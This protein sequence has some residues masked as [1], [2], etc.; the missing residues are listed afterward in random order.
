MITVDFFEN[1][2]ILLAPETQEELNNFPIPQI[3]IQNYI[4]FNFNFVQ[5]QTQINVKIIVV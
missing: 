1:I 2:I 5:T 3:I 4:K